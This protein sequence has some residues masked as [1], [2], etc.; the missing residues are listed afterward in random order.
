MNKIRQNQ[1]RQQHLGIGDVVTEI[2]V[3]TDKLG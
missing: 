1:K 3:L 2:L